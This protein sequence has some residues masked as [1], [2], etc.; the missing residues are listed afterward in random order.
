MTL[1]NQIDA[2]TGTVKAKARFANAEAALF[3]NQF[4]NVRLPAA[5]DRG[6]GGRAG[7]GAAARAERRLRLRRRRRPHGDACDR[8]SAASP[9]DEVIAI[10]Q[11]L[12]AGE[13][14]VTE[15]G[16]RLRDGARVQL[17]SDRPASARG[18]PARRV[19]R[20]RRCV[21]RRPAA[22]APAARRRRR[23]IAAHD[24]RPVRDEPV[25]P[26]HPAAGGD[27]AADGGDRAGR[28]RRLPVPAAVGA[29]AGRLPD[30]PGAD[31]LPRRQPRGDGQ[32]RHRAARAPVR[33]DGRPRADELDQRGGRLDHHAAVHARPD[34]RRRRAGGAGGD[35]RRRLAAARR[36]AGAAGLRQGQPGRRAG[37]DAG[38]HAPTRC[39]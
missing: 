12:E 19:G 26:V 25:A 33:P 6:R 32:H 13:R 38:D 37:A 17:P 11:G 10:A 15:G 5:H 7:D 22:T 23:L 20:R 24:R 31:A 14:V 34:A 28:P 35:Q 9:T 18:R 29:A 2:Q 30:D 8:S 36:P 3:P 27:L 4:V 39:R 16:D 1:D 21:G